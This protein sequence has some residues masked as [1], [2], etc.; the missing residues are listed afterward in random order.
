M[1]ARAMIGHVGGT[2][3]AAAHGIQWA[4]AVPGERLVPTIRGVEA[5]CTGDS[6][7]FCDAC[8]KHGGLFVTCAEPGCVATLHFSCAARRFG[9]LDESA[10][11]VL[12]GYTSGVA[13][14]YARVPLDIPRA[15]EPRRSAAARRTNQ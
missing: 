5:V 3:Q 7:G 1:C 14:R 8:G 11:C 9:E 13:G 15:H 10:V 12:A 2:E 4:P 6:E